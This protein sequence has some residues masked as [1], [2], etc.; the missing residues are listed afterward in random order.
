M[1][2]DLHLRLPLLCRKLICFNEN[3]NHFIFQFC[4]DWVPESSQL[5]ISIRSLTSWN[6]GDR[7]RSRD[8]QYIL[9]CVSLREKDEVLESIWK[10]RTDE[11]EV[12]EGTLF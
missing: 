4:D 5:T 3:T 2:I 7:V 12:L 1:I 9:H 6:F 8:F 10:Q 11:M